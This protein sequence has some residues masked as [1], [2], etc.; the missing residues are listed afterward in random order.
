MRIFS[1]IL[2]GLLS[3]SSAFAVVGKPHIDGVI[4]AFNSRFVQLIAVDGRTITIPRAKLD[5]KIELREFRG[6]RL[7]YDEN[8]KLHEAQI[9]GPA[10]T[11]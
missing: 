1:A 10:K 8:G 11:R 7:V 3:I 5:E 4:K 2:L 9:R 6:L